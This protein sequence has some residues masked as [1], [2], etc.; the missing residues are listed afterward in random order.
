MPVVN[1]L[2]D[3]QRSYSQRIKTESF[4]A[5]PLTISRQRYLDWLPWLLRCRTFDAHKAA[6][7]C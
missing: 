3:P 5:D 2:A 1:Y 4:L 7:L 6:V